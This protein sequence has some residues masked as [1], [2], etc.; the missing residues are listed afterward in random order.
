MKRIITFAFALAFLLSSGGFIYGSITGEAEATSLGAN[1]NNWISQN[2]GWIVGLGIWSLIMIWL[3]KK[4]MS[5]C[6][7]GSGT[8]QRNADNIHLP[9]KNHG[10]CCGKSNHS[11]HQE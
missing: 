4:G 5:C 10:A 3:H 2:I 6:S 8:H 1:A 7:T 9:K 11:P